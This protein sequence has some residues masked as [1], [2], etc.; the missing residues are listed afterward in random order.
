MN[1]AGTPGKYFGPPEWM[2]PDDYREASAV[3]LYGVIHMCF[4]FIPLIKKSK[5]RIINT[6]SVIARNAEA[7]MSPYAASKIALVGYSDA[8]RQYNIFYSYMCKYS[9]RPL[10]GNNNIHHHFNYNNYYQHKD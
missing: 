6:A 4:T 7:R 2:T 5:G 10:Y 9:I 3:N 1:N 8:L